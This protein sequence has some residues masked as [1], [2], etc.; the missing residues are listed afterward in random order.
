MDKLQ[1]VEGYD[2]ESG[3]LVI[4]PNKQSKVKS[5]Q[6]IETLTDGFI[7]CVK[8]FLQRFPNSALELITYMSTI[9]GTCPHVIYRFFGSIQT[10]L[11]WS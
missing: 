3:S 2:N 8:I 1:N 6:N 7:N 4:Q 9:R 11:L 5:I 10:K